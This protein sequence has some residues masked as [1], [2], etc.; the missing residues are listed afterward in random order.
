MSIVKKA[1]P[2]VAPLALLAVAACATP[3]R[4]DVARFQQM[5]APQGQSFYIQPADEAKLGGLE[6]ATYADIV[7]AE[8]AERG[9]RRAASPDEATLVVAMGYD[10]DNGRERVFARPSFGGVGYY[11]RFGYGPYYSPF[12]R[13]ARW[14]SPFYYGWHDPFFGGGFGGTDIHSYTLYT[15][16]LNL[17]IRRT[18]DGEPVFDGR[19]RARSRNDQ[20][21][22]LV[23]NLIEAMFTDFP[24]NSGEEV[25]ITVMPREEG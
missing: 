24:G 17:D 4:A 15:S 3:F 19:A 8:L 10:V 2:L 21:T 20:L 6:F 14:R 25:R 1:L 18:A 7:A 12:Y 13:H 16:E 5:P 23:P 22:E 11:S 9:F